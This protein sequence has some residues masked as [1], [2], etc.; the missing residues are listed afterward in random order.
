MKG[1]KRI[2]DFDVSHEHDCMSCIHGGDPECRNRR[3]Q[4][5]KPVQ[6]WIAGAYRDTGAMS[7]WEVRQ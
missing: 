6:E 7:N 5:C 4:A 2:H 3:C 1:R